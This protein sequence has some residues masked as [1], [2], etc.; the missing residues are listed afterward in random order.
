MQVLYE[1]NHTLAVYKPAG[2][3]VQSDETGDISLFELAKEY[4]KKKYKKPGEVYL[5]LVHRIDRPVSGIVLF[6][7]TSKA[8]ARYSEMFR[9]RSMEKTYL[10]IVEKRPADNEGILK[11]YLWKDSGANRV[12][13]YDK[14]K[15]GSKLAELEY[16]LLQEV[17][18]K[19]LLEVKPLTGRSHQIR[20]QLAAIRCPIIGDTKYGSKIP[21][22]D[23]SICLLAYRLSFIHPV[24]KDRINITSPIPE[25]K[26]WNRFQI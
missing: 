15:K 6:A 25:N 2:I 19:F 26:F 13:W 20:A 4:I 8:A 3:P 7:R 1:D 22:N 5:G 9:S 11:N 24:K 14:E 16:S 23:R 12:Y 21:L 18:N 10:A 17:D